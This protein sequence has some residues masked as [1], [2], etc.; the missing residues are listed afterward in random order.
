M[1]AYK[2]AARI[3]KRYLSDQKGR[4]SMGKRGLGH[5]KNPKIPGTTREMLVGNLHF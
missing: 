1:E 4:E 3:T 2:A 5:R